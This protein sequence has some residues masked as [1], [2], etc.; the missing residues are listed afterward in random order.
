MGEPVTETREQTF[1]RLDDAIRDVSGGQFEVRPPSGVYLRDVLV[2][3]E[4]GGVFDT[5]MCPGG[6]MVSIIREWTEERPGVVRLWVL[7]FG[8]R[9]AHLTTVMWVGTDLDVQG[10]YAGWLAALAADGWHIPAPAGSLCGCESG[11]PEI[12]QADQDGGHQSR[13]GVDGVVI[14]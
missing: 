6:S 12:E 10:R 8:P 5:E 9:A 7:P 4:G 1:R 2:H 14:E 3:P 11:A 13:R